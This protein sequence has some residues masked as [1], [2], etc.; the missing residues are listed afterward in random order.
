MDWDQLEI[1]LNLK[2]IE[3]NFEWIKLNKNEMKTMLLFFF[4]HIPCSRNIF[5][6]IYEVRNVY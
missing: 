4:C 3:I 2:S 5:N 1:D 6:E